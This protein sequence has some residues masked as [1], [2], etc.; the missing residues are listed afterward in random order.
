MKGDRVKPETEAEKACF[1]VLS[2]ID[3]VGGHVKGSLT[4]KKYMRNEVW[5]LLC[6]SH[7]FAKQEN[8]IYLVL[9]VKL[10]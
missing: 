7:E 2:D 1:K 3:T 10:P 4:S 5:S 8:T 6:F 9:A